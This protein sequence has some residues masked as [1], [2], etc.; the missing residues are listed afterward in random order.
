MVQ[1]KRAQNEGRKDPL[2]GVRDLIHEFLS[3][4]TVSKGTNRFPTLLAPGPEREL[5]RRFLLQA[6]PGHHRLS[7]STRKSLLKTAALLPN[8][9]YAHVLYSLPGCAGTGCVSGSSPLIDHDEHF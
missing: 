1:P 9:E 7:E 2:S 6:A 5:V 8:L 4:K 3:G